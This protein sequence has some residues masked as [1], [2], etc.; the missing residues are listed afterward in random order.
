MGRMCSLL[1]SAVA[2]F[3]VPAWAYYRANAI[4][5]EQVARQGWACGMP[6]LGLYLVALLVSGML[7]L[8]A[9]ILGLFAYRR[10]P[11]PR[12]KRR[13]AELFFLASPLVLASLAMAVVWVEDL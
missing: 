6:I 5:T 1:L 9:L 13:F 11:V 10:L 8:V 12:S 7:S 2:L 4:A 3:V